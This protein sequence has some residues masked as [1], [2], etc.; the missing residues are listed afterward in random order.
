MFIEKLVLENFQ[1]RNLAG[2]WADGS[3]TA[4]TVYDRRHVVGTRGP[5]DAVPV[6]G[7]PAD[8]AVAEAGAT[9]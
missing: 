1:E 8:Q 4:D 6:F 3:H 5:L 2:R 7:G 9:G